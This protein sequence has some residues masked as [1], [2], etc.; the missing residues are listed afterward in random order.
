MGLVEM[1]VLVQYA[2]HLPEFTLG[3]GRFGRLGRQLG[4]GMCGGYGQMAINVT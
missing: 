1:V 2:V 4:V 3:P